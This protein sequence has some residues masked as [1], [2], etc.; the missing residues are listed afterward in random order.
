MKKPQLK[1]IQVSKGVLAFWSPE[2]GSTFGSIK[3]DMDIEDAAKELR[4]MASR[5]D[6][7]LKNY[8]G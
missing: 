8:K 7:S 1:T 5:I 2:I 4:I 3:V 6:N